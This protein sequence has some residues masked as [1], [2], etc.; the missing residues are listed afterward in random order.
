MILA[1]TWTMNQSGVHLPPLSRLL[2]CHSM[3]VHALVMF[4]LLVVVQSIHPLQYHVRCLHLFPDFDE[5]M[6]SPSAPHDQ[7]SADSSVGNL[8]RSPPKVVCLVCHA[9]IGALSSLEQQVHTNR[10]LD[11]QLATQS[12]KRKGNDVENPPTYI[13]TLDEFVTIVCRNVGQMS[14]LIFG[15]Y[16]IFLGPR[17]PVVKDVEAARSILI[18]TNLLTPC[19]CGDWSKYTSF[20]CPRWVFNRFAACCTRANLG[21]SSSFA[22]V[23]RRH[24]RP[25]SWITRDH[26][27]YFVGYQSFDL[28]AGVFH[29]FARFP[30]MI[31]PWYYC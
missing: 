30:S 3:S 19:L 29:S 21:S 15:D 25:L 16:G 6:A 10:C 26:F 5:T 31:S 4:P 18:K 23:A 2:Y 14:S 8:S 27:S 9:R 28:G 11:V 22:S 12:K 24:Q 20:L 1:F 7:A 17:S 13:L